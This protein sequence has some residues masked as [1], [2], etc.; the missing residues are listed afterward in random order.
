MAPITVPIN[1]NYNKTEGQNTTNHSEK[2]LYTIGAGT[3]DVLNIY[4]KGTMF[5]CIFFLTLLCPLSA[6]YRRVCRDDNPLPPEEENW[7][8]C[9]PD[10]STLHYDCYPLPS[11]VLAQ[12]RVCPCQDCLW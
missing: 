7:L 2:A 9:D 11:V 10:V 4:F 1:L 8:L 6:D 5:I 12:Q 3:T